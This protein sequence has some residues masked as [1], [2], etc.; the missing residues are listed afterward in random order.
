[1]LDSFKSTVA[2]IAGILGVAFGTA[3]LIG[4]VKGA[5]EA[6]V[7]SKALAE[8]LGMT[9][10]GFQQL[11]Y[12]AK[13]SHVDGET[14]THSLEKMNEKLGDVATTGEGPAA[15]ALR[16]FGLSARALANGGTEHAFQTLV[17]VLGRIENPAERASV[18][19][20]L[21]GK[22]GQGMINLATKGS[23]AMAAMVADAQRFGVALSDVDTSKVNAASVAWTK[24]GMSLEGVANSIA[25]TLAPYVADTASIMAEM[26]ASTV[27]AFNAARPAVSAFFEAAIS[28]GDTFRQG[29]EGIGTAVS[30]IGENLAATSS[31]AAGALGGITGAVRGV[32][33]S[34]SEW[35]L[36]K[37]DMVGFAWRNLPALFEVAALQIEE[38]LINLGE[39]FSALMGDAGIL[40]SYIATNW[41]SMIV[42][43]VGAVG[44][45][46]ENL[47][48]NIGG[49]GSA[50][51]NWVK[52]PLG[53]FKFNWT[54]LLDGFR[55][56]TAELP[57]MLTPVLTSLQD[58]IDSK[59][60][61]IAANEL[62]RTSRLAANTSA[63]AHMG[64]GGMGAIGGAVQHPKIV[65]TQFAGATELG[66]KE[67]YSAVLKSRSMQQNSMQ[68]QI[69]VNAKTTA[70]AT[71]RTAIGVARL[72]DLLQGKMGGGDL[73]KSMT[74]GN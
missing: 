8:R 40:G 25:V 27:S 17:G 33:G 52:N 13:L 63:R 9:T 19:I 42:D 65:E 16:R 37:V 68:T 66:S 57:E 4:W 3:E 2:G 20:D 6:V 30:Q 36:D 53:E 39:H 24:V 22:A 1:M 48:K 10:K 11:Q 58:Q 62:A 14:L 50:I 59:L 34:I 73:G 15:D 35:I 18:A 12:A 43:A 67:A 38:K 32:G 23:G 31:I 44:K 70:E 5:G 28:A 21:F 51:V 49:I 74:A 64:E 29:L 7:E 54:P 60:G 69:A 71:S 45:S 47:G 55:V 61:S 56:T 26:G 46:F 41:T 72:G